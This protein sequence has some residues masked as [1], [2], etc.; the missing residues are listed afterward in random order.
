MKKRS[1]NRSKKK[2]YKRRVE[3][4]TECR[5]GFFIAGS[6]C[7]VGQKTSDHVYAWAIYQHVQYLHE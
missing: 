3:R 1:E 5:M 4:A 2:R 6:L 7:R